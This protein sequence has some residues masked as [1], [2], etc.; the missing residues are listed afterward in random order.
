V[1][2]RRHIDLGTGVFRVLDSGV[3]PFSDRWHPLSGLLE[4]LAS[5]FTKM[6][7]PCDFITPVELEGDR[8]TVRIA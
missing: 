6:N 8:G 3:A 5:W 1:Q 4:A 7:M 2:R